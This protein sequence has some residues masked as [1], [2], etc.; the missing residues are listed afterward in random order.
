MAATV[1]QKTSLSLDA[2]ALATARE[3]GINVSAVADMALKQAVA[4]ARRQQWM[5]ENAETFVAQAEWHD[6]EGHPLADIIVSPG[7]ATWKD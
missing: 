3:M 4:E 2:S 1:K 5:Q 6:R 7:A